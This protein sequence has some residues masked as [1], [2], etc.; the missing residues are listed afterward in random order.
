MSAALGGIALLLGACD[1][2]A[3]DAVTTEAPP[4]AVYAV[5]GEVVDVPEPGQPMSWIALHHEAIPGFVGITGEP[6]PMHS[7]TMRFPVADGVDLAS[8]GA[9]DKV[10]FDLEID[11]NAG[12]PARVLAVAPLPAETE[13]DFGAGGG[14][15]VDH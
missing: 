15:H 3:G 1:D 4:A 2:G 8:L 10:A 6:E 7:M 12:D 9:G 14:D 5:R 11:W 13:L